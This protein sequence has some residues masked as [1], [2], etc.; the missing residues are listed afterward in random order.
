MSQ[1]AEVQGVTG[2]GVIAEQAGVDQLV[3]SGRGPLFERLV[4]DSSFTIG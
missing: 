3:P 1:G 4:S 2:R